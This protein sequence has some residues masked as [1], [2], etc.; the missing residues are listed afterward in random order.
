MPYPT[1]SAKSTSYLLRFWVDGVLNVALANYP[2]VPDNLDGGAPQHV[3]LVIVQ[4]L[5]RSHDYRL[6][7]VN[8]ERVYVLHVT[9]LKHKVSM[10]LNH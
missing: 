4:R 9:H 5:T 1:F 10:L 6:P 3:V 7:R 2:Q 8:S